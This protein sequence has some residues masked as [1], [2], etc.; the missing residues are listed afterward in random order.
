MNLNT[1]NIN[2]ILSDDCLRLIFRECSLQ[3]LL[4]LRSICSR[5]QLIIEHI[6]QSKHSLKLF[7]SPE[8]SRKFF[9]NMVQFKISDSIWKD[10]PGLGNIGS[11]SLILKPDIA[12]SDKAC[13]FLAEL[14]PNIQILILFC[15]QLLNS[16]Q[17]PLMLNCWAPKLTSLIIYSMYRS[18]NLSY[19]FCDT[20]KQMTS[21]KRLEIFRMLRKE[22]PE[23]V[24]ILDQLKHFAIIHYSN[25]IMPILR[26]LKSCESIKLSWIC[27]S[28]SQMEDLMLENPNLAKNIQNLKLGM[29]SSPKNDNRIKNFQAILSFICTRFR[30]LRTLDIILTDQV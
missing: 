9:D 2:T 19:K 12:S 5:W 20:F 14:F 7:G 23:Q 29:I 4:Q 3:Q 21:L 11:D 10:Y 13:H 16:T 6:F 17:L 18:I 8:Y 15:P 25:D 22:I 30:S 26:Q 27:L 28:L 24:T 1:R